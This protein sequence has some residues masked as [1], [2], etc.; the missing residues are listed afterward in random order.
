MALLVLR[1]T[2]L[3]LRSGLYDS[4]NRSERNYVSPALLSHSCNWL[5]R[6]RDKSDSNRYSSYSSPIVHHFHGLF[7]CLLQTNDSEI[8]EPFLPTSNEHH[9]HITWKPSIHV[10]LEWPAHQMACIF[11]VI[12]LGSGSC[13]NDKHS[14]EPDLRCDRERCR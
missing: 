11:A 6:I 2:V 12:N 13:H 4:Q 7:S 8:P 3:C 10:S 1:G 9:D 5:H 14:N